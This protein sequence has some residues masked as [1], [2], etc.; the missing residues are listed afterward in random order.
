MLGLGLSHSGGGNIGG[1]HTNNANI[2][3]NPHSNSNLSSSKANVN[4]TMRSS[5]ME[6]IEELIVKPG[7]ERVIMAT[8][9]PRPDASSTDYQAGRLLRRTFRIQLSISS[10]VPGKSVPKAYKVIQCRAKTCTSFIN[11][12]TSILNF[13][14][15][16]VG[17]LKSLP[18]FITNYSELPAQVQIRFA[19][20]ILT[21]DRQ[22]IS[23]PPKQSQEVKFEIYPRKVNPEYRKQVE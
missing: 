6:P 23:I 17:T 2:S 4:S 3:G 22:Q 11:T 9:T 13:G 20:K 15:T 12:S 18:L 14:D 21:C 19:S 7:V 10:S 16:D 8:Y 1:N 5:H